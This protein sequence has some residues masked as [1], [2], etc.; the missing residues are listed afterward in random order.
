[1]RNPSSLIVL[2]ITAIPWASAYGQNAETLSP[3]QIRA[4]I[5]CIINPDQVNEDEQ[6]K[7][8]IDDRQKLV[9]AI[10]DA[11]QHRPEFRKQNV[12]FRAYAWLAHLH[13]ADCDDGFQ[14]LLSGLNDNAGRLESCRALAVAPPRRHAKIVEVLGQ[15]LLGARGDFKQEIVRTLG[16]LG[17][18]SVAVWVPIEHMF[19][20]RR[21]EVGL[22]VTAALAMLRIKPL[23]Q[24][25]K[26]AAPLD[27]EGELALLT[28]FAKFGDQTKYTFNT[29]RTEELDFIRRYVLDKMNS[30]EEDNRL[31]ALDGLSIVF[32]NALFVND[33]VEPRVAAA[34]QKM[35]DQDPNPILRE[36]ASVELNRLQKLPPEEKA[37]RSQSTTG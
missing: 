6:H 2:T 29:N 23:D 19:L 26:H 11:I 35:A 27:S 13:A 14:Q 1:M 18:V 17:P 36:R 9:S 25:L 12:R 10:I 28:A 30:S 33:Q 7:I 32:G 31:A 37:R 16:Q 4:L 22:R 21:A 8:T 34:M 15:K 5:D 3:G 24:T 20:S